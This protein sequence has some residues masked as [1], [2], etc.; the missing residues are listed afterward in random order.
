MYRRKL[1]EMC[2]CLRAMIMMRQTNDA[3]ATSV[4][5]R[6]KPVSNEEIRL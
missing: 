6:T 1:V 4:G 2:R 3:T 5:L